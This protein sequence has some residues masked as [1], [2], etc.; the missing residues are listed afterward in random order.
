MSLV[1]HAGHGAT[2]VVTD[3]GAVLRHRVEHAVLAH[4]HGA[5]ADEETQT[6]RK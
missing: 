1:I 3:H 2:H 6:C 5:A 4:A